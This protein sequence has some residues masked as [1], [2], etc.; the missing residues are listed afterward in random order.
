MFSLLISV[1][2][3]LYTPDFIFPAQKTVPE[4]QIIL[5]NI[6]PAQGSVLVAVYDRS[7]Y[8]MDDNK[9]RFKQVY[10]VQQTGNLTIRVPNMSKGDYAVSCYHDQNSN[11]HLDKN[12]LGIPVEPYGFSNNARPKLRAPSWNEAKCLISGT[13]GQQ[14]TIRLEKW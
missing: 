4:L 14:L 1:F 7:A 8:F 13:A 5:T 3:A 11:Q 12:L 2:F 10:P 6:S 9:A